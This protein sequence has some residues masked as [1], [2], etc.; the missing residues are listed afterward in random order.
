MARISSI[1]QLREG[2]G[3][4][5]ATYSDE[6]LLGALSKAT[7]IPLPQAAV[8]FGYDTARGPWAERASSSLDSYQAGLY[9][10]GEAV[11]GGT[12][13]DA[14][15]GRRRRANE[16]S[17]NISGERSRQGGIPGNWDEITGPS[18]A[19]KYVGGLALDSAPYV[20]EA[21]AGGL[22]GRLIIGGAETLS[23]AELAARASRASVAGGV[24]ASYPSSVG[25]IL[26]NQREQAGTTD[27]SSAAALGVPYAALN[28]FGLESLAA[29]ARL[30]RL[31]TSALDEMQGVRGGL[32][33]AGATGLGLATSEG[34]SEAGQEVANQL[35]RMAV[36]PNASLTD[37]QALKRYL[38]SFVG[39]AALGGVAGAGF[40]G[41]RRSEHY[42]PSPLAPVPGAEVQP[43]QPL[44]VLRLPFNPVAGTPVV[45]PDGT[46]ALGSEAADSYRF[47]PRAAD[48]QPQEPMGPPALPPGTV[49][50]APIDAL[51]FNTDPRTGLQM[52]GIDFEQQFDTGGLTAEQ[53]RMPPAPYTPERAID[54]NGLS[55]EGQPGAAPLGYSP[56][57]LPLALEPK[58][59]EAAVS[60]QTGE[61][62]Q[63]SYDTGSLA[64]APQGPINAAT[65]SATTVTSPTGSSLPSPISGPSTPEAAAQLAKT[66]KEYSRR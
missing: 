58:G 61:P 44:D 41:W 6:E 15:F 53:G 16:I 23:A 63:F 26:Q 2:L 30:P 55:Y 10:V 48:M 20:A 46:I 36:D 32:A 52:P 5:A 27:L 65:N 11:L 38:D 39:G 43:D 31:A 9:G 40:G 3:D 33:R 29:R 51:N 7:G 45:F 8:Q 54:T 4:V 49:G 24:A 62:V 13:L 59:Q 34:A 12:G 17:A 50:F 56:T 37:E 28:A 35:G 42:D 18:S 21:A 66:Q 57:G 25:D 14:P 1:Q 22:A 60:R 47:D 64:L 19:A